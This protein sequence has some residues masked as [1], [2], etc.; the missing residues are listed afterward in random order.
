MWAVAE[1]Q[2]QNRQRRIGRAL[3][4]PIGSL[5]VIYCT[6]IHSLTVPFIVCSKPNPDDIIKNIWPEHWVLPFRIHP[7]GT[8]DQRFSKSDAQKLLS[9]LKDSN[10]ITA[11][12]NIAPTTVFAPKEITS[13]DWETII[14]RL[15]PKLGL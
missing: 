13:E 11:T 9:A 1:T 3:A 14:K 10:N 6:E 8:P 7:L 4:M 12:L 5:G 15:I 2:P